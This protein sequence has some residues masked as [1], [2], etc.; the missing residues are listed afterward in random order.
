MD[1]IIIVVATIDSS[2]GQ[3]VSGPDIV[4]RGFVYVR[5]NEALMNSARTLLA[6]LLMKIIMLNFTIGMQLNRD[7]VMNF[8]AL[9]TKEQS[10]DL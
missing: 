5:E 4:S 2:T 9:C 7:F 3:V 10:A 1:G 8:H 6:E